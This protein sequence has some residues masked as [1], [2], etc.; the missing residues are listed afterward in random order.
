MPHNREAVME[1]LIKG[2]A[3]FLGSV[4]LDELLDA[5]F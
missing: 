3:K 5:M 4:E 2:L 1:T